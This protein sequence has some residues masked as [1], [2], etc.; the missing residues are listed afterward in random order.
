MQTNPNR[1]Q[2]DSDSSSHILINFNSPKTNLKI[3]QKY[4]N[5]LNV[6][7]KFFFPIYWN[8]LENFQVISRLQLLSGLTIL[9]F[10]F[11]KFSLIFIL[12]NSQEIL[13]TSTQYSIYIQIFFWR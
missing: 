4:R 3:S 2:I 10:Q 5:F 11:S 12:K 6:F 13:E 7:G 8:F 1:L 9:E